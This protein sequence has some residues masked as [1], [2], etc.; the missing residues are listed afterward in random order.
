MAYKIQYDPEMNAKYPSAGTQRWKNG[1][2]FL[3]IIF[4]LFIAFTA[5]YFKDTLLPILIPGDAVVTASA[6]EGLVSDM[7]EGAPVGEA[8]TAFCREII[9]HAED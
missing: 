9:S 1:R 2:K 7:R 8:I 3:I 5:V 6:F 4:L